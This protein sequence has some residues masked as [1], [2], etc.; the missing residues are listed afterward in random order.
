MSPTHSNNTT[1]HSQSVAHQTDRQ[2][3]RQEIRQRRLRLSADEQQ[4]ASLQLLKQAQSHPFFAS[5][6]KIAI[7]LVNDGEI[8]PIDVIQWLWACGKQV[9]LPVVH[10]FTKGHLLFLRYTESTPLYNN[11]FGIPEPRL[12]VQEVI[13]TGELDLICT[14]LVA[15]DDRGQRL[16][17][18][19]G[20]YDRTLAPFQPAILQVTP[21]AKNSSSL[22]K[23]TPPKILG[24]AH[25]CQQV[26]RLPEESWDIPLPAILTPSKSWQWREQ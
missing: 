19:G 9:Y 18:G 24:L 11:Q 15:F 7:Y 13:P 20:F 22:V 14:P 5:A 2:R 10:P 26:D 16:G 25:D 8:D 1:N 21:Q 17:M 6:N 12:N 3:L 4:Q 23:M